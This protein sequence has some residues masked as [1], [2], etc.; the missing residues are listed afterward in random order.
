VCS[1]KNPDDDDRGKRSSCEAK[2]DAAGA[3]RRRPIDAPRE[4]NSFKPCPLQESFPD[5]RFGPGLD[6][7]HE[8][9][10]GTSCQRQAEPRKLRKLPLGLPAFNANCCMVL[11]FNAFFV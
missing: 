2:T 1:V 8:F 10:K 7:V 5:T 9:A 11:E 4:L 3:V 6:L